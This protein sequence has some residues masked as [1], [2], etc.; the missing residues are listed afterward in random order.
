MS[1]QIGIL[2]IIPV[3]LATFLMVGELQAQVN[4]LTDNRSVTASGYVQVPPMPVLN[5]LATKTPSA[6]FATFN[7]N[8]SGTV[9]E[10][11]PGPPTAGGDSQAAQNSSLSGNQFNFSS[12]L[13]AATGGVGQNCTVYSEADSFSELTF[14]VNSPQTWSLAVDLVDPYGNVSAS[15]NLISAQVGLLLGAPIPN[16]DPSGLPIYYQ[17]TLAPGDTYTLTFALD[18]SQN[19]PDPAGDDS[20]VSIDATFSV[21]PEPSSYALMVMGLTGLFALKRKCKNDLTNPL[22]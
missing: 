15:W 13:S 14:S 3:T 6:S 8:V 17:G 9:D 18:A 22:R 2:R 10:N 16:P 1:I 5:Y 11:Y 20:Q 19:A 7:G 4:W 21:V 12:S